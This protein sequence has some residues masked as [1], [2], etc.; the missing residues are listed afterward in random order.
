MAVDLWEVTGLATAQYYEGFNELPTKYKSN[1]KM[2]GRIAHMK[3]LISLFGT[4][5]S[6]PTGMIMKMR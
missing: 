5:R 3:R 4:N 1:N 6:S 2:N